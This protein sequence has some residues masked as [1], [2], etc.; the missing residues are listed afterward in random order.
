MHDRPYAEKE[1]HTKAISLG[2]DSFKSCQV[3]PR[4]DGVLPMHVQGR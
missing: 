2:F 3:Q 4:Q 1:G